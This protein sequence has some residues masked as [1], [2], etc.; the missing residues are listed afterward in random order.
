[1][2]HPHG[3][4]P[5]QPVA[6]FYISPDN[7]LYFKWH[8]E[9]KGKENTADLLRNCLLRIELLNF[10]TPAIIPLRIPDK[11]APLE[12]AFL[13]AANNISNSNEIDGLPRYIPIK[14]NLDIELIA[15]G[16]KAGLPNLTVDRKDSTPVGTDSDWSLQ[17]GNSIPLHFRVSIQR[18]SKD[19]EKFQVELNI[20]GANLDPE[21]WPNISGIKNG[22][23]FA[24]HLNEIKQNLEERKKRQDEL[25]KLKSEKQ[26]ILKKETDKNLKKEIET[27]I[28]D[29][30]E[31]IRKIIQHIT[32]V[33]NL[34]DTYTTLQD[35]GKLNFRVYMTIAEHEID[36]AVTKKQK[37]DPK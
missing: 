22:I 31:Q 25:E 29:I 1:M 35:N 16:Q 24:I 37:D 30:E 5:P 33:E 18:S 36:L 13:K 28:S 21:Q 3:F 19:N 4:S 32:K 8:D 27:K 34:K 7:N 11:P 15:G 6:Q 9:C 17:V 12:F 23:N 14:M 10:S 20:L 26:E 2:L